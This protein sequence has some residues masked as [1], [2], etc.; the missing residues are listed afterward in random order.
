MWL[1]GTWQIWAE[2]ECSAVCCSQMFTPLQYHL[3]SSKNH[4][5]T[6]P[7]Q[8]R[9]NL[10]KID[11]ILCQC[12]EKTKKEYTGVN[13]VW[14]N[15]NCDFLVLLQSHPCYI[16]NASF[17]AECTFTFYQAMYAD[18]WTNKLNHIGLSHVLHSKLPETETILMIFNYNPQLIVYLRPPLQQIVIKL[19]KDTLP[20]SNIHFLIWSE[21]EFTTVCSREDNHNKLEIRLNTDKRYI[22]NNEHSRKIWI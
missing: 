6:R 22:L 18:E 21:T 15:F 17:H 5:Q 2:P 13:Q 3:W 12:F 19:A 11:L 4:H 16:L 14:H 10:Q 20:N 9:T 1:M 8:I 7:A